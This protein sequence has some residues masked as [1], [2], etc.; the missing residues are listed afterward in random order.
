MIKQSTVLMVTP[1]AEIATEKGLDLNEV[2]S[3]IIKGLNQTTASIVSFTEDN[4]AV[5]L[6]DYTGLVQDHSE[7]MD[8]TTTLVADTIRGSLYTI[9]K[10]IKPIL[11]ETESRI[12]SSITPDSAV[13]TI[14]SNVDL[15]MVNVEPAFLNSYFY[16]QEPAAIFRDIKTIRL[17]EL[18]KGSYPRMTGTELVDLIS[19]D[20]P[21]LQP[22]FASPQEVEDV[23]NG[24]F[25]DKFFYRI[26]NVDAVK[27]GVADIGSSLNYRFGS[28]RSLVIATLILN[29]LTSMDDP[30]PG[31]SNVSLDDYRTSLSVTR[32]LFN[33]MLYH[34]K[35]I[36]EVRA[37]AGIVI[38]DDALTFR[39]A[40]PVVES[41]SS[42]TGT[43]DLIQGKLI[44]G[45]NN[46]V[47]TM[48]ADSDQLSLSEYVLGFIYAKFRNYR[49]KDIITDKETV[50]AAWR[51]Y[52]TD[53]ETALISNKG[54]SAR[55]AFIQVLE[56]LANKEDYIPILETMEDNLPLNQRLSA[57]VNAGIN[58][59][60]FFNNIPLLD[61]VIRENQSLMNTQLAVVMADAFD[62]PIAHEILHYNS[63]NPAGTLEQ[64][65]KA[66]SGAIDK[67]I[68]KR[69]LDI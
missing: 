18:L 66:L 5:D 8:A 28:F 14:M 17:S 32:D 23:Y 47:L 16:P 24:L 12:R 68:I 40:S 54:A 34:F 7:L 30:I 3:D 1:I 45:Y 9:A 37:A 44:I 19:L 39:P 60:A 11:K 64:Q 51:E 2:T 4:I 26:F 65:R 33:T 46:A 50:V 49:V 55:K 22:Y 25:V 36:W 38:I 10:V 52:Q 58:L 59:D 69:L 35:Q 41:S 31:V 53:V 56:T 29:K 48:F 27:D 15:E 63:Q 13:E 57:R 62:S 20:V 42:T 43:V 67:V 61:A 6:P 21:D